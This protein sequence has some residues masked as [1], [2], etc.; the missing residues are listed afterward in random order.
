M[1]IATQWPV[2]KGFLL[3]AHL[4]TLGPSLEFLAPVISDHCPF[5]KLYLFIL[6]LFKKLI[7][8][9][10]LDFIFLNFN[11]L[12]FHRISKS[13]THHDLE[14]IVKLLLQLDLGTF[15]LLLEPDISTKVILFTRPWLGI[16]ILVLH[17]LIDD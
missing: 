15:W 14:F 5:L 4:S 9:H 6:F 2:M 1:R 17:L 7:L 8:G 3:D 12:F 16:S 10:P 11:L 13:A